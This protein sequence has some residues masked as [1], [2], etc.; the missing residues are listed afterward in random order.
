MHG[1]ENAEIYTGEEWIGDDVNYFNKA[2]IS[3]HYNEATKA[4]YGDDSCRLE[5]TAKNL[6]K[7]V[8]NAEEY[9]DENL[10]MVEG[11][12]EAF[13]SIIEDLDV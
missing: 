10:Q 13:E 9:I 7:L 12:E 4:F 1:L 5:I 3:C 11:L 2:G 8:I 6:D